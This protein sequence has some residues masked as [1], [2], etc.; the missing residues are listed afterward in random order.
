[1]LDRAGGPSPARALVAFHPSSSVMLMSVSHHPNT[2]E[3]GG[4]LGAPPPQPD[5]MKQGDE[6]MQ[7]APTK[8]IPRIIRRLATKYEWRHVKGIAV[9]RG[10]V[11]LW[12]AFL[13]TI[14]CVYGYW[15]GA[16]LLVA[17]GLVA[18]LAYQMPHWKLTLDAENERAPARGA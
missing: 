13:G 11:A 8:T 1:M 17:A 16:F 7:Q 15:W 6:L 12:L 18:W 9:I 2:P 10:L 4:M 14:L 5:T 3:K